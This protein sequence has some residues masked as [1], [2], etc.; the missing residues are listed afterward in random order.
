M[1]AAHAVQLKEA[2]RH[3]RNTAKLLKDFQAKLEA[4]GFELAWPKLTP[5]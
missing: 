3:I 5:R 1:L 2:P 4:Q